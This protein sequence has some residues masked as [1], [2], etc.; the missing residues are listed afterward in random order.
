M[1]RSATTRGS[2]AAASQGNEQARLAEAPGFPHQNPSGYV[3]LDDEPRFDPRRHF[4]FTQPERTW[5]LADLGYDK[6]TIAASPSPVAVAGPFR[7]LSE[8]GAEAARAIALRLKALSWK[9]DRTAS[10]LTGGVYRSRFLRD[11]FTSPELAAFLSS[12]AGTTLAPHSMPSQQLYV[13]YA[14]EDITRHVDTWHTDSI[15]FDIVLMVT[16]PKA[17][18]G[19]LFQFFRGSREEAAR[20]L[21][22]PVAG[23]IKGSSVELPPDRIESMPFPGPGYALFQQGNLVL[24]RA[25]RLMEKGERITMVPGFVARDTRFADPTN[26]GSIVNWGEPGIPAELARHKAWFAHGR[27]EA[28]MSDLPMDATPREAASALRHAIAD[29]SALADLLDR[30]GSTEAAS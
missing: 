18:K 16:D 10:Y 1:N 25:T 27:L 21:A 4:A 15:G 23:L 9:S 14:P 22:A 6:G 29:A 7:V 20:L 19:G 2:G 11:L 17:I 26:V 12:V 28:V 30:T 3:A 13:N 5:T 8:E 24:H